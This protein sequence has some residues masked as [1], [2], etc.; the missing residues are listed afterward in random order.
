M[1][2]CVS[3]YCRRQVDERWAFCPYCGTDNRPPD[4][5]DPVGEHRHQFLAKNAGCCLVCGEPADEPYIF[6]R[7][8]RVRISLIFLGLAL[9]LILSLIDIQM[10]HAGKTVPFKDWI[11]SWYDNPVTHRRRYRGTYTTALGSD[12]SLWL[13]VGA[14]LV[15]VLSIAML[16]K[17][18]LR[19]FE[20][21]PIWHDDHDANRGCLGGL[22]W[23]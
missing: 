18:P 22:R 19:Y 15:G 17:A 1:P 4:R 6:K 16:L 9:F 21:R 14:V 23:W 12:V 8:W 5:R 13:G 10:A 3:E 2:N 11:L 7:V 20:R